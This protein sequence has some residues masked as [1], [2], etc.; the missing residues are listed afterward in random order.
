MKHIDLPAFLVMWQ[1]LIHSWRVSMFLTV[2]KWSPS[3]PLMAELVSI[4]TL[5]M[6]GPLLGTLLNFLHFSP[7]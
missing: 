6:F 4:V 1:M 7:L 3:S 5:V 2:V